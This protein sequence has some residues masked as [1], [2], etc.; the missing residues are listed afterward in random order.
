[1]RRQKKIKDYGEQTT[2][3]NIADT[4]GLQAIF[5]AYQREERESNTSDAVLPGMEDVTNEQ[6]F[7]LSFASTWCEAIK[8]N[9]LM[10]IAKEDVHSIGRLRV[11]GSVSNSDDFAKAYNCPAGSPMNPEKKCNI[12][13]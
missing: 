4:M 13:K 8:P 11:I 6:L 5:K 10:K 3:D 12:W 1:M 7:F 9:V 2:G